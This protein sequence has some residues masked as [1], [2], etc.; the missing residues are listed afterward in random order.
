VTEEKDSSELYARKHV[1]WI[2]FANIPNGTTVD[3][4][5]N[6]GFADFPSDPCQCDALPTVAF[7]VLNLANDMHNGPTTDP[8]LAPFAVRNSGFFPVPAYFSNRV[9]TPVQSKETPLTM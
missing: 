5:S 2:S 7:V 6:L 1:P 4:S 3:T 9:S 8:I